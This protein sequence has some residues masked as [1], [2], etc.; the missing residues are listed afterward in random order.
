MTRGFR[1]IRDGRIAVRLSR[2]EVAL[3]RNLVEQVVDL[4]DESDPARP[5]A[6]S[7]EGDTDEAPDARE[8]REFAAMLGIRESAQTPDDPVLARLLPDGYRDD[9]EAAGEFRRYTEG[10]LRDSKRSAAG[11]VLAA[12][13][14][15]GGTITLDADQAD[16]WLRAL[17]DVRLALGTRLDIDED[18]HEELNRMDP[19]DPR[20]PGYVAYDWL[21]FLQETLVRALW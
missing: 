16:T 21:S 3:L 4:I 6:I 5:D 18:A 13:A 9:P 14:S 2:D 8:A 12:T 17:N 1:K 7:G 15:G 20:Y 10:E 11:E 19:S